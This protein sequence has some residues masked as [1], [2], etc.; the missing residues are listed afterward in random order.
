MLLSKSPENSY[1]LLYHP[2]FLI[3]NTLSRKLGDKI[4]AAKSRKS[5]C[6]SEMRSAQSG[7]DSLKSE[8]SNLRSTV[9]RVR[10]LL[11]NC[12]CQVN[13]SE[14]ILERCSDSVDRLH[15]LDSAANHLVNKLRSIEDKAIDMKNF[16]DDRRILQEAAGDF[17][18]EV[19]HVGQGDLMD[20]CEPLLQLLE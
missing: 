18:D 19:I 5:G 4:D 8:V 15:K 2:C 17:I 6:E 1:P 9:S 20:I 12:E 11:D 3:T 16:S 13:Q 7:M 14:Y 10:A